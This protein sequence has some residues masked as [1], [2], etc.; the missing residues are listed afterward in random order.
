MVVAVEIP[1]LMLL[2]YW[3]YY[4]LKNV[5]LSSVQF[6]TD[7]MFDCRSCRRIDF[8]R[9]FLWNRIE[10]DRL[11]RSVSSLIAVVLAGMLM[12]AVAAVL[13]ST[14]FDHHSHLHCIHL[15]QKI[16]R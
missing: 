7:S 16:A 14:A 3:H 2:V 12:T 6:R 4:L 11:H 10:R 1:M 9:I 5:E 8:D 13:M 15:E